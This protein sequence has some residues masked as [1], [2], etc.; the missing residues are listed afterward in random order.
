M[1]VNKNYEYL[2]AQLPLEL[3]HKTQAAK[4]FQMAQ[5]VKQRAWVAQTVVEPSKTLRQSFEGSHGTYDAGGKIKRAPEPVEG[6]M[7]KSLDVQA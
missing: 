7:T 5:V 3:I 4:D 1:D 2:M 6:S